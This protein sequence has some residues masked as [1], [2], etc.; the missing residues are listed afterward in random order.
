ML[1]NNCSTHCKYL[2]LDSDMP[3]IGQPQQLKTTASNVAPIPPLHGKTRRIAHI[4]ESERR[5]LNSNDLVHQVTKFPIKFP[6][7]RS[8]FPTLKL[9]IH[10][11]I[12][13]NTILRM[14]ACSGFAF[15]K[16]PPN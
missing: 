3:A 9:T 6:T 14:D 7:K 16:Y 8:P 2:S 5:K 13:E 4:F 15:K 11:K 12:N 10:L 1:N